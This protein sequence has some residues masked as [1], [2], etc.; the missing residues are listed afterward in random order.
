VVV[1]KPKKKKKVVVIEQTDSDEETQ[2]VYIKKKK[3]SII[4]EIEIP[5]TPVIPQAPLPN[6]R[7]Q[8]SDPTTI[9]ADFYRRGINR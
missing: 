5:Q 7:K 3:E 6:V 4:K 1:K 9:Y 2:V 8:Y